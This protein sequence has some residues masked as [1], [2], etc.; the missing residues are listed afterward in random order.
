MSDKIRGLGTSTPDGE[1]V[2]TVRTLSRRDMVKMTAG[3]GAYIALNGCSMPEGGSAA[4]RA[5]AG[6]IDIHVHGDPDSVARSI[7]VLDVATMSE[8]RG[9]RGIV[10]KNHYDATAGLAFL[11]R[12]A[13][14]D[15]EVFGGVALNRSMG[16][17]NPAAVQHMTEIAGGWGRVVWMPTFDAEH[18]VRSQ[19]EDRP[20]VSVSRD[21]AL[22]SE[23]IDVIGL[24]AEHGLVLATGHSAPAESLLLLREARRQGVQ[25]MVVTTRCRGL[26]EWKSPRCRQRCPRNR[27]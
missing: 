16:G 22:L 25:Q 26:W 7:D 1:E 13:A 11:A 9:L 23:T 5:L 14:P 4:D 8:K 3:A 21:G 17:L 27:G 10:L 6:A 19:N 2:D 24:I 12:K 20:F 18:H 15:L